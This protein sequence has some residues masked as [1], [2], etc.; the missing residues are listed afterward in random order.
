MMKKKITILLSIF[1]PTVFLDQLLKYI[2]SK[3]IP[4]YQKITVVKNFF[5]ID[6]VN[7]TG[8]A[9]G[10]FN[11]YSNILISSFTLIII[12]G[13]IIALFKIKINS[14]LFIISSSLVI[15]GAFSN[16]LN[17]LFSKYVV[18]FLDFHFYNYHWPSFN[19]ADSCV[20]VGTIL[21]F[22]SIIKYL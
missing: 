15:S 17:R 22:V 18:D 19:L 2:V 11:T 20:V 5:N 14:N 6:H 9:F 8:I 3:D 4:L 1:I 7:N 10:L 21:F 13:I 16:L 12:A